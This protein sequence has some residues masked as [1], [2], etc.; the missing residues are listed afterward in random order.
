MQFIGG[1]T[2]GAK[3]KPFSLDG[4]PSIRKKALSRTKIS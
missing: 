4:C 3:T 1:A 2:V